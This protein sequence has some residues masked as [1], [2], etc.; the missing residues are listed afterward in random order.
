MV[1]LRTL[2]KE[3]IEI[4]DETFI[5]RARSILKKLSLLSF[6]EMKLSAKINRVKDDLQ[7]IHKTIARKIWQKYNTCYS[8]ESFRCGFSMRLS[9]KY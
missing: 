8:D 6:R 3:L 7:L 1:N 9:S 4:E 2:V 5:N